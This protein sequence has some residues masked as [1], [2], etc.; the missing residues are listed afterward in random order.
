MTRSKLP[1]LP[2]SVLPKP[3]RKA[4]EALEKEVE[5]RKVKTIAI[6]DAKAVLFKTSG[7]HF[8]YPVTYEDILRT[9]AMVGRIK[10]DEKKKTVTIL[11]QKQQTSKKRIDNKDLNDILNFLENA[12]RKTEKVFLREDKD[13]HLV[14]VC[15]NC[16]K[17]RY[18]TF[19]YK[20]SDSGHLVLLNEKWEGSADISVVI[21]FIK[22]FLNQSSL[23]TTQ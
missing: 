22:W 20:C 19:L 6:D 15:L 4:L 12:E 1:I 21:R 3:Y 10:F 5:S 11:R 16:R 14:A 8:S 23:D 18:D 17:V 13:I 2:I 7:L 9:L